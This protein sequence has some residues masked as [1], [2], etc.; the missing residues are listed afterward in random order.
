MLGTLTE[1]LFSLGR[2]DSYLAGV[3]VIHDLRLELPQLLG[4]QLCKLLCRCS[5]QLS[6]RS[7]LAS[8]VNFIFI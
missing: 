3:T 5:C 2:V 6:H 4:R 1:M 8:L 7:V